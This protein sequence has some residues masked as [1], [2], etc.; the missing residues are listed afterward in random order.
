MIR[1][2]AIIIIPVTS[3]LVGQW[4][5]IRVAKRNEKLEFRMISWYF[6]YS[7]FSEWETTGTHYGSARAQNQD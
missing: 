1:L 3:V 2:I 7:K 5:Q 4:L 6:L